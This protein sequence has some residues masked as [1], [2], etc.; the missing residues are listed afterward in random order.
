MTLEL[1]RNDVVSCVSAFLPW[2]PGDRR[3]RRRPAERDPGLPGRPGG[4]ASL[5]L[6]H[7]CDAKQWPTEPSTSSLA[8][9][10]ARQR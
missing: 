9:S 2:G 1:M 3:H 7:R 6:T 8:S 5:F 10:T 4:I